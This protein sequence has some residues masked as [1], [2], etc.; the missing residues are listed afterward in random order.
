[1]GLDIEAGKFT[2]NKDIHHTHEG[3]IGNLCNDKIQQLMDDAMA[4]FRFEKMDAAIAQL[5]K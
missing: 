5:L 1:V 3:S 2:P 4:G